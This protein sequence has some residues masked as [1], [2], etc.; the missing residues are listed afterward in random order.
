MVKSNMATRY[1]KRYFGLHFAPG[2]AQY[3][4]PGRDPYKIFLNQDTITK[5]DHTFEGKL[6]F[7]EHKDVVKPEMT[8]MADG[9]V[10]K[11][12][13][14]SLDGKQ[15][16]EFL[17]TTD[18]GHEAIARGYSLSNSYIV[19]NS[20]PGGTWHAVPYEKEVTE[21]DYDHLA[22]VPNPRYKESVIMTPAEFKRYNETKSLELKQLNNSQDKGKTSM[23]NFFKKT[24]VENSIDLETMSVVLPKCG[25]EVTL[26]QLINNA[27]ESEDPKHHADMRHMVAV[28]DSLMS[29]SDLVKEHEGLMDKHA[30]L[31]VKHDELKGEHEKMC[32]ASEQQIA[33][34]PGEKPGADAEKD[35]SA[36][37]ANNEEPKELTDQKP[38]PGEEKPVV[39]DSKKENL[40]QDPGDK[41]AEK[42]EK[43]EVALEKSDREKEDKEKKSNNS[44]FD[45]L[46]AAADV[47]A[48]EQNK[49]QPADPIEL[50]RSLYGSK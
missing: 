22:L 28:R 20:G 45:V 8:T 14:N 33:K 39:A 46:R 18:E 12:F 38:A 5:C 42:V 10:V 2:V 31:K 26:S 9:I 43:K 19:K 21:L 47:A 37:G 25:K 24:K 17:V 7:V 44:H 11:S 35:A 23:F 1:P 49:T 16:V 48:I 3:N 32:A 4:E 41:A 13:F 6:L 27:D 30:S 34:A 50:G 40:E 36:A 29:I 15:W